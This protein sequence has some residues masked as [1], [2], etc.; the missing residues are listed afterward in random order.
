[1]KNRIKG[2]NLATLPYEVAEIIDGTYALGSYTLSVLLWV[3]SDSQAAQ[4]SLYL[5]SVSYLFCYLFFL[6]FNSLRFFS[7]SMFPTFRPIPAISSMVYSFFFLLPL[8]SG[9]LSSPVPH[10][11]MSIL[12]GSSNRTWSAVSSSPI[13]VADDEKDTP[14]TPLANE[15][16]GSSVN[17]QPSQFSHFR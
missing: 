3:C 1:M 6:L 13:V 4:F 17:L 14:D 9:F 10:L 15:L 5:S 11:K 12:F 16:D 7:L 8:S 2:D